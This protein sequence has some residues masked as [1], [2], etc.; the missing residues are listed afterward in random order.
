MKSGTDRSPSSAAPGLP[1][2]SS[3]GLP[4]PLRA[5]FHPSM[6]LGEGSAYESNYEPRTNTPSS[7]SSPVSKPESVSR[8]SPTAPECLEGIEE[9]IHPGE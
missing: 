8:V 6:R 3:G 5:W 2:R 7:T 4:I 1:Y 9:S